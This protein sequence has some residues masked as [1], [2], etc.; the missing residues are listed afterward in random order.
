MV[1]APFQSALHESVLNCHT[2]VSGRRYVDTGVECRAT[3]MKVDPEK[4]V[5]TVVEYPAGKEVDTGVDCPATQTQRKGGH[6]GGMSAE[7]G[8]HRLR[9][10]CRKGGGQTCR[11][12]CHTGPEK[13]GHRLRMSCKKRGGHRRRYVLPHRPRVSCYTGPEKRWIQ[14]Y[15]VL[16]KKRWTHT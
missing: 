4:E 15:N 12:S 1:L 5:D 11:M 14:A 6:R 2:D 3:Q 7:R 10:S 8:G 16:Q 9:M 13:G